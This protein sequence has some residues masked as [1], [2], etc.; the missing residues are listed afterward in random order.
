RRE[1]GL[2]KMPRELQGMLGGVRPEVAAERAA[3][4]DKYLALVRELHRAGVPVVAGTDI[5]VPGHSVHR[6]IE[7]YVRAGFT[8]MEAIQ[9]A[10]I[11]PARVM[12]LE[13]EAGSIEAGKRAD[14]VVVDGDPLADIG[15][16]R[17]VSLVVTRGRAYDPTTLW[18]LVGFTP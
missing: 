9:A 12:R 6:E 17:K 2:A 11:V 7:L 18:K 16:V 15:N 4:F 14:L 13:A 8:P 10:T 3:V 5:A 1:P